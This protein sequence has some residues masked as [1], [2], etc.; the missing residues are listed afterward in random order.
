MTE[1]PI[2]GI[3]PRMIWTCNGLH[4]PLA[5]KEPVCPMAA[6]IKKPFQFPIITPDNDK[7]F[8]TEL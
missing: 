1:F 6:H 2:S 8:V 5:F 4:I 3:I 7:A